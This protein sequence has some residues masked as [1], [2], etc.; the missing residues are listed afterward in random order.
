MSTTKRFSAPA[1]SATAPSLQLL[2][3]DHAAQLVDCSTDTIRRLVAA[4]VLHEYRCTGARAVRVDK[5]E[6]L[7]AF[8]YTPD[9]S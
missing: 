9:G 2:R 3:P 8:G 4:G 5:T 7:R 6:L 1:D